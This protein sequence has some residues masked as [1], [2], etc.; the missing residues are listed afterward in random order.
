M[1]Q[2]YW[3]N[4]NN[5]EATPTI[6]CTVITPV[7]YSWKPEV[8]SKTGWYS[9]ILMSSKKLGFTWSTAKFFKGMTFELKYFQDWCCGKSCAWVTEQSMKNWCQLQMLTSIL[10]TLNAKKRKT[11]RIWKPRAWTMGRLPLDSRKQEDT[12]SAWQLRRHPRTRTVEQGRV[13]HTR[14]IN[15]YYEK[16]FIKAKWL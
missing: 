4:W 3:C 5:T 11:Q 1:T 13:I 9:F 16:L 15:F 10:S 7:L 2:N 6:K 14:C 8:N 12:C